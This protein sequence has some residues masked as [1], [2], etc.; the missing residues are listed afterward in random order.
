MKTFAQL[1]R[2]YDAFHAEAVRLAGT[3]RQLSQRAATYHH[4]YE[5]SGRNHI[6]PLIAAHGALWARGYFAFGM[7][8]GKLLSCQYCLA[9][10][11]R[12]QKLDA[13]EAFAEAFR[14]VNRRVCVQIYTTYHFTKLYGDHPDTEKLVDPHLLAALKC[15]HTA[16]RNGEQLTDQAKRDIFETHFLNEQETVVGPRIETAVDQFDW[17]L[18]KSLALM[19]AVR[20]AYFPIGY[21]LQFWKFDRKEERIHH[22]LKA[23]DIAAQMGWKHTEATLDRY[24]ILP[25]EFFADS[26]GHFSHL[27]NEI[28]AAA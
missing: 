4:V 3:T 8:L 14:E 20:F 23:F 26:I 24:A 12:R 19:P 22:G 21:W 11:Q 2:T 13:L 5:D 15:V 17:P 10:A 16:N 28:L 18:M 7:N 1:K 25:E 27:K 9:S 6:F